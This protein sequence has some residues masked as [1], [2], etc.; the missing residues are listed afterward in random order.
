METNFKVDVTITKIIVD[1]SQKTTH[2]K[3]CFDTIETSESPL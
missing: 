3:I 1:P 2:G